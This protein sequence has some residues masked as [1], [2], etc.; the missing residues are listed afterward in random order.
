[1]KLPKIVISVAGGLTLAL[2]AMSAAGQSLIVPNAA[3]KADAFEAVR[4]KFHTTIRMTSS[5]HSPASPA[6]KQ[7]FNFVH[8][9]AAPGALGGLLT[10]DP[11]DGKKHPAIVWITGGDCNSIGGAELSRKAPRS[12]D[13][14]AAAYRNAGIVMFFPSL[15][16]GN[17]NPGVREGFYGEID[18]VLAAA[19]YLAKQPYVDPDRIYLGGHST[20]GT[21]ALLTAEASKRFRAVFAFGAVSNATNYGQDLLPV[22]FSKYDSMETILRM[23]GYWLPSVKERLFVIE[24]TSGN[25]EHLEFMRKQSTNPNIVF[26]AVNG[27]TH[28]SVLAPSNELIAQKILKDEGSSTNIQITEA[29]LQ[30]ANSRN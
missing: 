9:P 19:D 4:T 1:M 8:Y 25:I 27:A 14:T 11:K 24:G 6:P 13:Q 20:G 18:D 26:L 22:D 16:G 23:P 7:I 3:R 15:R 21:L 28:F 5:D 2:A 17:D 29:E 30:A 12:N 10:P